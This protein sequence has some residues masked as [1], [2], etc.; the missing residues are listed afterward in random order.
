MTAYQYVYT[1]I[2][3]LI[4]R[5]KKCAESF[6]EIYFRIC[7]DD[8]EDDRLPAVFCNSQPNPHM[9]NKRRRKKKKELRFTRAF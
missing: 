3:P 5:K 4:G 7:D 1:I 9:P 2:S 6:C 8:V